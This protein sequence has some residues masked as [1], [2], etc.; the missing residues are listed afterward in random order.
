[1]KLIQRV[2]TTLGLAMFVLLGSLAS[3]A[4]AQVTTTTPMTPEEIAQQ[5]GSGA[6]GGG[7][8]VLATL[9]P[10]FLGLA[11]AFLAWRIAKRMFGLKVG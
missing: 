3:A 5:I 4:S 11:L 7:S 2:G 8:S 10:Y 1:M 6:Q 9:I